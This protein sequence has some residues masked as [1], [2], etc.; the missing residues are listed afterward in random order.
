MLMADMIKLDPQTIGAPVDAPASQTAEGANALVEMPDGSRKVG[1][2][3]QLP[4]LL[5][6][7]PGA[8]EVPVLDGQVAVRMPDD[9]IKIGP[10]A[11][12][13]GLV[14]K[15]PN[16][17]VVVGNIASAA[18]LTPTP[19]TP[20]QEQARSYIQGDTTGM[21]LAGKV[22]NTLADVSEGIAKGAVQTMQGITPGEIVRD[23]A[24]NPIKV[25]A[26]NNAQFVGK[27]IEGLAEWAVGSE[28]G[29]VALKAMSVSE[30][31]SAIAKMAKFL[32][33]N[34]RLARVMGNAAMG[35]TQTLA[36]GGTLEQAGESALV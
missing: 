16:A 9:S 20:D 2:R 31:L 22:G 15:Y 8:K 23:A 36:K 7:Y 30:R 34:P 6:A 25:A 13:P 27:G 3:S 19:L 18:S 26:T 24:G 32:E 33:A 17:K 11:Q 1:P 5:Q 10:V 35:G 28:I 12:L 21:G 14:Q 29:S 4:A